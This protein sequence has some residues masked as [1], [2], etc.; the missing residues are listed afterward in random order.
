MTSF[1]FGNI[2]LVSFPFTDQSA[3]KKKSN[4]GSDPFNFNNFSAH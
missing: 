4:K 3:T 1:E 2:V